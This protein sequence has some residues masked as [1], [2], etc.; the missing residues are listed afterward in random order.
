MPAIRTKR[1]AE[2]TAVAARPWRISRRRPVAIAPSR[3]AARPSP[4]NI[5]AFACLWNGDPAVLQRRIMARVEWGP[6][7][8]SCSGPASGRAD[9]CEC[10]VRYFGPQRERKNLMESFWRQVEQVAAFSKATSGTEGPIY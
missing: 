3:H 4:E 2:E 9:L 1:L 7:E 10:G 8:V 6:F 5:E